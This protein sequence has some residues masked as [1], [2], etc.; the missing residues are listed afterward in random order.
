M[1]AA[2]SLALVAIVGYFIFASISGLR[3]NIAAAKRS[4]LPYVV[5]R[6]SIP[7]AQ[8]L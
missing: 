8:E 7:T 3:K 6:M 4:G 5:T 2:I 1:P